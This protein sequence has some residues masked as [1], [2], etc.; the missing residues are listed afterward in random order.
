MRPLCFPARAASAAKWRPSGQGHAPHPCPARACGCQTPECS[1]PRPSQ[2]C[3][4]PRTESSLPS[5]AAGAKP[6]SS[7]WGFFQT[8]PNPRS[9]S[10]APPGLT[11]PG[12]P[13]PETR[14]R[15]SV[16]RA[17]G[18]PRWAGDDAQ[19]RGAREQALRL[20][21]LEPALA[22]TMRRPGGGGVL[23]GRCKAGTAPKQAALEE[24]TFSTQRG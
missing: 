7:L 10:P 17:L 21:P 14:S 5:Q 4:L 12:S 1:A 2:A 16:S 11:Q 20:P 18:P 9:F 24:W 6:A 13:A 8:E 15:S 22:P 3:L 23:V 19:A